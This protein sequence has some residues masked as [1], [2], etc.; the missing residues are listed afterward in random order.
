MKLGRLIFVLL[1]I[2]VV[3]TSGCIQRGGKPIVCPPKGPWPIPPGC[4]GGMQ[5]PKPGIPSPSGT[6]PEV[7]ELKLEN[8]IVIPTDLTK[9]TYPTSYQSTL[10]SITVK[11]PYCTIDSETAAYPA[12]YLGAY[13]LPEIDGAPLPSDIRRAVGIKDSWINEPN[14]NN[15]PVSGDPM[16]VSF[17][18]TL[19]RAKALGAQEIHITNFVNFENFQGATLD[20]NRKAIPD[21]TLQRIAEAASK[22]GLGV[23]LYLNVAPGDQK[24]S[25]IPSDEW[26]A[27]FIDNYDPFLLNQAA[28]AQ[29]TGISGIM[30]G[31]FDYQ[32][33]IKGHED[34]YNEKM[35]SLIKK[36]RATYSGKI[37]FLIEPTLGADLTK[38]DKLL[39]EVDA[40]IYTPTTR[41]L[42]SSPDKTVSV[43]NIREQYLKDF[44]YIGATYGKYKKP[45]YIRILIQSE[46]D[47][48]V[49]GW[50]E[51]QFC[52]KRGDNSCYQKDLTVDFSLQAI[53]YEAIM[54]ALKGAH[55]KYFQVGAVDTYGYW[56]TDVMLPKNSQPQMAHTIRNKPAESIVKAWFER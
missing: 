41:P 30:L 1:V 56:Y 15:C 19:K 36:V 29:R 48:L 8:T 39:N 35:L 6:Q 22:N 5:L 2:S 16:F 14:L 54:E 17:E 28:I 45:V 12:S 51:D 26:L 18:K 9:I 34:V 43:S 38:L 13:A 31:H 49:N 53:A 7:E 37:V 25:D 32:P 55:N 50:N 3:L 42:L 47:F 24:V 21:S 11:N 52:I 20:V 44:E 46:K 40:Y 4:E 33:S 27:K 23:V 10:T